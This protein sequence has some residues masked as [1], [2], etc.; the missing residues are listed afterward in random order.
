MHIWMSFR[1][2][3]LKTS[4]SLWPLSLLFAKHQSMYVCVLFANWNFIYVKM[5]NFIHMWDIP[6]SF[7]VHIRNSNYVYW[8]LC[9]TKII[10]F[11]MVLLAFNHSKSINYLRYTI[12][13]VHIQKCS[14]DIWKMRSM[15]K[16][17]LFH[18]LST[19]HI[20]KLRHDVP[21]LYKAHF[22]RRIYKKLKPIR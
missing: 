4:P 16:Q 21:V 3:K 11:H 15:D 7:I 19:T 9:S 20:S 2:F 5:R 13:K 18:R 12:P 6:L 22:I 17:S 8:N 10:L 1:N 14:R